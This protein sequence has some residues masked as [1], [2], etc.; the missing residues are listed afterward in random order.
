MKLRP[1]VL[2]FARAMEAKLR[3]HDEDRGKSG[4]RGDVELGLLSATKSHLV[5]RLKLEVEEYIRSFENTRYPGIGDKDE[6]CDIANF[7]MML[8]DVS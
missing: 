8:F 7:C 3:L 5:E 2:K 6:L 4:W 1:E